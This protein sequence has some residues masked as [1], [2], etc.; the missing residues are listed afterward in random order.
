MANGGGGRKS[1]NAH[2]LSA[3]ASLCFAFVLGLALLV[4]VLVFVFSVPRFVAFKGTKKNTENHVRGLKQ[5]KRTADLHPRN[6]L[7]PKAL[8]HGPSIS[9]RAYT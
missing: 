8:R 1:T 7:Q 6:F 2:P 5:N 9:E 3:S 4:L